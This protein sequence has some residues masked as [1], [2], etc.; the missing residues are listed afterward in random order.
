[1]KIDRPVLSIYT[2]HMKVSR[3]DVTSLTWYS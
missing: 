3:E 2:E 1:M